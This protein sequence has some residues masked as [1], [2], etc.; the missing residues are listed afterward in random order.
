VAR[1]Y[2]L[3]PVSH[4]AAATPGSNSAVGL[5]ASVMAPER[6]SENGVSSPA[7]YRARW[8]ADADPHGSGRRRI[9]SNCAWPDRVIAVRKRS[10]HLIGSGS[11]RRAA[12]AGG[13]TDRVNDRDVWRAPAVLNMTKSVDLT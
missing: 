10:N 12:R 3:S 4:I 13:G 1:G 8:L 11:T 2:S 7:T 9:A 6:R 5:G